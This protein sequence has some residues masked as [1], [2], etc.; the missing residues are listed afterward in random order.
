MPEAKRLSALAAYY[1]G[2]QHDSHSYEADPAPQFKK[3]FL[4]AISQMR[5][6]A[7]FESV[8]SMLHDKKIGDSDRVPLINWIGRRTE[9]RSPR[10]P[11]KT[12]FRAQFGSVS[13]D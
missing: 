4:W 10:I 2:A 12:M 13:G 9:N 11:E 6:P 7:N 3:E 1:T 8:A 5:D